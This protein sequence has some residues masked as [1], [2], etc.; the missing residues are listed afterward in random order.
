M[1]QKANKFEL[2]LD[3][4]ISYPGIRVKVQGAAVAR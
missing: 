3:K 4:E 1:R 2:S